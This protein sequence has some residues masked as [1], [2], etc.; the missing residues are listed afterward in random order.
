MDQLSYKRLLRKYTDDKNV[1][2]I[3]MLIGIDIQKKTITIKLCRLHEINK[4]R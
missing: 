2:Q 4:I 3:F 1:V